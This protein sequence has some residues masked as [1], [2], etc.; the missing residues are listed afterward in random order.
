MSIPF[1]VL[2]L[3]QLAAGMKGV[4]S[5][6]AIIVATGH[7]RDGILLAPVTAKVMGG[8]IMGQVPQLELAGFSSARFQLR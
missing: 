1:Q 3:T 7:F 4:K 5:W 8:I 2:G 6:D